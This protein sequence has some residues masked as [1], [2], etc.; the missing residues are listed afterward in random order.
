MRTLAYCVMPDRF[1]RAW[2]M[3]RGREALG[4][5]FESPIRNTGLLRPGPFPTWPYLEYAPWYQRV[6]EP[7]VLMGRR[8]VFGWDGLA[9]DRGLMINRPIE[10]GDE[11]SCAAGFGK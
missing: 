2:Y 4:V 9:Y 5:P 7:D 6:M 3:Y 8:G 11:S 1:G 10:E